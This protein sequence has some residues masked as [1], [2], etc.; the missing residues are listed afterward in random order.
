[1]PTSSHRRLLPLGYAY[2]AKCLGQSLAYAFPQPLWKTFGE[3]VGEEEEDAEKDEETPVSSCHSWGLL[4]PSWGPLP[5]GG[6]SG[7]SWGPLWQFCGAPGPSDTVGCC[8]K[9]PPGCYLT[10]II[11]EHCQQAGASES[12]LGKR[13]T[14]GHRR[15]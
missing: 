5:L 8:L 4:G 11:L 14:N 2:V 7:A 15:R 1:M 12:C 10:T 3:H 13:S 6:L 9:S